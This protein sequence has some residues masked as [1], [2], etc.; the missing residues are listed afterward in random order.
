MTTRQSF[1]E[2]F[3]ILRGVLAAHSKRLVVTCDRPGNYQVASPTMHDRTGRP[4]FVG[5][6]QIN[7][8]Y[9]SYHLMPV[10]AKPELLQTMSAGLKRRMQG[11]SC[12]NFTTIESDHVKELSAITKA[13]IAAFKDLKLPWAR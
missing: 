4:L 12:F 2:T 11:K 3:A 9:V 7:K 13:G 8:N 6:V 1:E 5:G 10:Y